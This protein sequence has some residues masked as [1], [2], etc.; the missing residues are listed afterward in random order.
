V[1]HSPEEG[2]LV[3]VMAQCVP[4][5]EDTYPFSHQDI[6]RD[7]QRGKTRLCPRQRQFRA[8][9]AGG[10]SSS[11]ACTRRAG[12]LLHEF[13]SPLQPWT[14][15]LRCSLESPLGRTLDIVRREIRSLHM[16]RCRSWCALRDRRTVGGWSPEES[17][18]AGVL[19]QGIGVDLIDVSTGATSTARRV[20]RAR[21]SG[22][23]PRTR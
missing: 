17:V 16:N 9:G 2:S 15:R 18:A 3:N 19:A 4:F 11:G 1:P 10:A 14:G 23:V 13:L 6:G 22:A 7:I 8:I 5:T 20:G 12:Y 21:L